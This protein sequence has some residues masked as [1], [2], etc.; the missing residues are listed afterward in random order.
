MIDRAVLQF[1]DD[2]GTNRAILDALKF[3]PKEACL[4]AARAQGFA[5]DEATFDDTLWSTEAALAEK[6]GE[7]FDFASSMWE[8]MWGKTYLEYLAL[9]VAPL[10]LSVLPKA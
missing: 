6:I 9:T 1:L 3:Q 10:A 7:P 5:F 8:T 2:I 4:A